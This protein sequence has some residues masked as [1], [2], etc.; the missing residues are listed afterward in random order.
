[1][2]FIYTQCGLT[3]W[4]YYSVSNTQVHAIVQLRERLFNEF[5][6]WTIRFLLIL[7]TLTHTM[8]IGH[9]VLCMLNGQLLAIRSGLLVP[10][11]GTTTECALMYNV[12]INCCIFKFMCVCVCSTTTQCSIGCSIVQP[13]KAIKWRLN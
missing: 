13:S 3:Q 12:T 8:T 1:M 7:W 6:K 11:V 2:I 4:A 9:F 5:I 10:I